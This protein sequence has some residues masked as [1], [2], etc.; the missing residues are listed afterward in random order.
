[1][2]E[3]EFPGMQRAMALSLNPKGKA[4]VSLQEKEVEASE[5][6]MQLALHL[7]S[8]EAERNNRGEEGPPSR[9]EKEAAGRLL[10]WTI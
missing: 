5:D 9:M 6:E 2:T 8:V 1:M 7:S 10:S 3:S 4:P